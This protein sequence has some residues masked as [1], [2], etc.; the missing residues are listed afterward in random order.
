[1]EQ[2]AALN[3]HLGAVAGAAS[4]EKQRRQFRYFSQALI[5]TLTVFGADET[6][7]VQYCPMAFDGEGANWISAEAPIRNPYYG[8]AMLSCGS[9]VD[10]LSAK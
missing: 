7:Y 6:L 3:D 5:N 2:L 4:L 1:M 9:T 8:D 10:T